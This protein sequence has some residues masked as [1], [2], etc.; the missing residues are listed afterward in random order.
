V[1]SFGVSLFAF[2]VKHYEGFFADVIHDGLHKKVGDVNLIAISIDEV[3]ARWE[4]WR[5][6]VIE[7]CGFILQVAGEF[8]TFHFAVKFV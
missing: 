2:R 6:P 4:V 8:Y 7:F 1:C 5:F 3:H